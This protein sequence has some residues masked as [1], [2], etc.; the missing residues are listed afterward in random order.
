[1]ARASSAQTQTV[2]AAGETTVTFAIAAG[3]DDGD[4]SVS[5]AVGRLPAHEQPGRQ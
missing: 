2:V 1:M 4:V 5:A 3:G